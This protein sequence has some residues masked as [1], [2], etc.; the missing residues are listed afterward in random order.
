M[1]TQAAFY[2]SKE[3]LTK[4]IDNV[5]VDNKSWLAEN[6]PEGSNNG[7][8]SEA[9]IVTKRLRKIAYTYDDIKKF[10]I[11][12]Q[13]HPKELKNIITKEH[14]F[15][16]EMNLFVNAQENKDIMTPEM[17]AYIDKKQTFHRHFRR[18]G[19]NETRKPG[20]TGGGLKSYKRDAMGRIIVEDGVG[21]QE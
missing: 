1:R 4:K 16:N 15:I 3:I 21:R 13:K 19:I 18:D 5:H 10:Q 12:I 7:P 11:F 20:E 9:D 17:Q 6:F 2:K 8:L 14:S